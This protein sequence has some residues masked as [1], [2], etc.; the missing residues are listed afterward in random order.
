EEFR[1][2]GEKHRPALLALLAEDERPL[3]ARL[4]ALGVLQAFWNAEVE[5]AF[6]SVL[7]D[8]EAG[9][10]RVAVEG[11]GL[12]GAAR[13]VAGARRVAGPDAPLQ[14]APAPAPARARARGPGGPLLPAPCRRQPQRP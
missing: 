12:H 9:L 1:R 14:R 5:K 8:G 3:R 2:R 13:G 11:L 4:A 7:L 6:R 10:R